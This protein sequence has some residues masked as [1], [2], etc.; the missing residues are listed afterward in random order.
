M[1]MMKVSL[2]LS[3]WVVLLGAMSA[4]AAEPLVSRIQDQPQAATTVKEWRAQMEAQQASLVRVTAVKVNPAPQGLQISLETED[5][6]V[7]QTT[8][9]AEGNTLILTVPN[10]LLVGQA[11]D[12]EKP[13]QGIDRITV[14]QANDTTIQ[15]RITGVNTAPT[16]QVLPGQG[17][18]LSVNATATKQPTAEESDEEVEIVVTAEREQEGY[19]VPDTSVGT[20][21]D[22]PLRDIP[23]LIQ[24]V[25]KQVLEEQQVSTLNEALRNTPGVV[26]TNSDST[27]SFTGATIRGFGVGENG[28]SIT[29]NG[30]SLGSYNEATGIFSN[31]ERVEVLRGPASVLFGSGDPG[32]TINIVTKQPLR[33]P[34]YSFEVTAGSY[35]LYGGAIDLTGSLNDSKTA[36]YR[37]NAA[38]ENAGTFVER[39]GA[40]TS[41]ISGVLS[42]KPGEN[43]D[44]SL[45]AEYVKINQPTSSGLPLRGSILP[46]LNGEIPRDRNL[47]QEGSEYSP[48]VFRVGYDL[49]H[50]FNENWSL[51]N[52][53]YFSDF[54][55]RIRGGGI[56]SLD[57]DLRTAQT[58]IDERSDARSKSFDLVTNVVGRF[59]TGNIQHQLLLGADLRRVEDKYSS[60][61]GFRGRPIDIFDPVYSSERFEPFFTPG[62]FATLTDSLG[63]YIQDQITITENLKLLLGSRFDAFEQ[64]DK[65][66]LAGTETP[67]S[68]SAFS[69]RL[70]IVYQPIKPISLYASYSRSFTPT[71]GRSRNNEP[72]EPGR[73]T[74]YE[75]GVKA[76]INDKLSTTL[77]LYDL[78]RT[79]VNTTDPDDPNFEIQTGEQN[80][81]GVELFV[82]GEILPGWNIIAGYA[83]TDAR[84]AKDNSFPVGNQ[85]NNVPSH[86]FNLWSSYEIQKGS[87]K[88]LGFGL[89]FFY[90]G[91]RP[92]DLDNSFTL[93]S[94][95]RTDAAIFYKHGRFRAALNFNNLFNVDYFET[96]N[97]DLSISPGEP[98]TLQGTVSWQF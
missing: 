89:G 29:R 10:A 57:P 36:L 19:R 1:E 96:G 88:G 66:L 81:R 47:A 62:E 33:D 53:F 2:W 75:I 59:S 72:F 61:G 73:G 14:T 54:I 78:T 51:R 70:G 64:T 55:Y 92:G 86:S 4:T 12:A 13:E 97:G 65:D 58:F 49:E 6:Q 44:L 77:A 3:G 93:P 25:P 21:T 46:N 74:Q 28:T 95:L 71:I 32:G 31:I 8:Q 39:I 87:L 67:Q 80:S 43:T 52:A 26:Q 17:L 85:I 35:N 5:G 76:D 30:L 24:I 90:V 56:V 48:E 83:Y 11:V 16:A 42:F 9:K 37:L 7:L 91:D 15:I 34:L 18:I 63:I 79:N 68:G 50:R 40:E 84:I 60:N 22:T 45:N 38:Y 20:R 82:S 98:L 69:P 94:Y 41:A 27:P 23:A